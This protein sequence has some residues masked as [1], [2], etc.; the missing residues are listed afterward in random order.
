MVSAFLQY[1]QVSGLLPP[2]D[3]IREHLHQVHQWHAGH[4]SWERS[5]KSGWG[6]ESVEGSS[7]EHRHLGTVS[8]ILVLYFGAG[9]WESVKVFRQFGGPCLVP[10]TFCILPPSLH[11]SEMSVGSCFFPRNQIWE[12]SI[13]TSIPKRVWEHGRLERGIGIVLLSA[14]ASSKH[15]IYGWVKDIHPLWQPRH[16]PAI[17]FSPKYAKKKLQRELVVCQLCI[18][19]M[20]WHLEK[21]RFLFFSN[22][23]SSLTFASD[24]NVHSSQDEINQKFWKH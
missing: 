2:P 22:L 23:G 16:L 21:Q 15:H 3:Y 12:F 9:V 20:K 13:R 24:F 19:N 8:K 17:F 4:L 10:L 1:L 14:D 11:F 18:N 5:L 7:K 6:P